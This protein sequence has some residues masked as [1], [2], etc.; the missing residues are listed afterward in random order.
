MRKALISMVIVALMLTFPIT[1]NDNLEE[2]VQVSDLSKPMNEYSSLASAGGSGSSIPATQYM[3]R[4]ITSEQISILNT[5]ADTSTHFGEIDLSS[6]LNPG[7]HV[8]EVTVD[9]NSM[10]AAPERKILADT[11][12]N[13]NFQIV[14]SLGVFYS[15]LV[16]GFYAQPH[17][18]Q[19]Q[20][21]SIYYY[22]DRYDPDVRGN[23]SFA[24]TSNYNTSSVMTTPLNLTESDATPIWTTIDGENVPLDANIVYWA[25]IN[26]STC[27][28]DLVF[29]YYPT[30]F[31]VGQDNL[32]TFE[33]KW[34][35]PPPENEWDERNVEALLNYTYTPWNRTAGAALEFSSPES[36]SL[37]ADS[38]VQTGL[39]WTFTDGVSNITSI[40]FNANQSIYLNYDITIW[41]QDSPT[42]TTNWNVDLSGNPVVWNAT[43][44]L[45]YPVFPETTTKYLDMTVQTD[46]DLL[47]LYNSTNPGANYTH[48]SRVGDVVTCSAMADETWTLSS[49]APNYVTAIALSNSIDSSPIVDYVNISV[50][51]DIDATVEDA[52]STPITGG[53]TNLTVI[54]S[55]TGIYKPARIAA[56]GGNAGFTWDIDSTTSG[57]GTHFVE[58]FWT[59]GLEAGYFATQVFVYYPT[60]LVSDDSKVTAYA[61]NAAAFSIGINFDRVYP[62]DGMDGSFA[63]VTYSFGAVVNASLFDQGGGRW[64]ETISTTG[65][66]NGTYTLYVY[67]EGYALENQSLTITVKLIYQTQAL[68]V[69]WSPTN[70]IPYLNTTKL[71]I[72]YRM[73][74]GTN[75]TGATVNVSI[76][77]TAYDMAWD[78]FTETYWIELTGEN[79]TGVPDTFNLNVSAWGAGYET[80]FDDTVTITI[81]SQTGEVFDADY[82]PSTL[83]ISYI[84]TLFIQVT[85]EYNS[86][87]INSSTTVTI[88]FNGSSPVALLYNAT[89]TK[90]EVTLQ[91]SDYFGT[92]AI[93]VTATASGYT[94]RFNTTTFIVH[95]DSPILSSDWVGDSATTIYDIGA[96]LTISL[97]D[98]IGIPITDAN[99]S[100]TAFGTLYPLSS[101]VGGL[102]TF[103]I[104]PG[105]IWGIESFTVY[106]NRT[107]FTSLQMNLNLTV[108]APTSLEFR[109]LVSSE[110]EEWNLTLEARYMDTFYS[111]PIENATVTVTLYGTDYMLQYSA[112]VYSIEIIL[113]SAPGEY[114]IYVTAS[115]EY[116]AY[117]ANQAA[118]TVHPKEYVYLEVTFDGDLIAGQFIEIRATLRSNTT[119][120]PPIAGETIRFEVSVYFDNGTII[121]Y[122]DGT[123]IDS[124]NT[125]GVATLGFE[126]PFGN[127]LR[128]T[129]HAI[130]D[131]SQF[132]WNAEFTEETGV[133]VSPLSLLLAFFMSDIGIL[134]IISIAFLGIVAAGY[135]RGVKPKKKAAKLTLENELQMFKDLETVQHFMAV[136][137]DRGTCVFYHP[138]T[139]E[140]IQ[141]DLISGF[142]AAITSVYGEIK[143]DGVRGTLEEIQYHGLRL[144]SYSGQYII[145]ILILEGEMTTLLRERLQFFV[146]LFE[147]QY[148]HDLDG[149]TGLVDCFD[150]EWVVSTLNSAF[151]YAWHLPHR[152]GP[153]Q[154]VTKLDAKILDYIGAVRDERS[155][156][157]FKNLISPLAEMLD[158]TEPEVLDR[159]LLLQDRGII[160]PIGIQTILQRQ[161]LALVNGS[162]D[163]VPEPPTTVDEPKDEELE[164][165]DLSE[166]VVTEPQEAV[167]EESESDPMEAFVQDVESLLVA[168]ADDEKE[169]DDELDE[170]VKDLRAKIDEDEDSED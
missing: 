130:Y 136:Y 58:V 149:W 161:G 52:D 81:G 75:I 65:M 42:V 100:F 105:A 13:T 164:F 106:V 84:E 102:Y 80:Q 73:M 123:M 82:I 32:G 134:M 72:T 29:S 71:S 151:N 144:N 26:G 97:T 103:D 48:A 28:P 132:R 25:L 124:T 92:W 54:Q 18:G 12:N 129:A 154:K 7:W 57:N 165:E 96:P 30:V 147:N 166:D 148:D 64:T 110:Y 66:T 143:G 56:L 50:D 141:P 119:D 55:G 139:D 43:T 31:W 128:L 21:Y 19:L 109:N 17:D 8:Y 35:D 137:L 142:I 90:W 86:L 153:T 160:A 118:F 127:I 83:N 135:N 70:N 159:L 157:Y 115:A 167:V 101:G 140:R 95:E 23:A 98:S 38:V 60:T 10:V 76:Q 111:M 16:Q 67:S 3:S 121:H 133:E 114:T 33:S 79:F 24:I 158:K 61:D 94:T 4:V 22:T 14:E 36:L 59:N 131:G 1:T 40:Q 169:G 152:F 15:Q 45:S 146:E 89:S 11:N 6:Y 88:T 37:Q 69:S 117:A 62:V 93:N 155:E 104:V 162:D 150:P 112:G 68:S 27:Y 53:L 125:E 170:F 74:D 145:G 156:F 20:N 77:G 51:M 9:V 138:F 44:T 39:S 126:V 2:F 34:Y 163:F 46:W 122:T 41:Y 49:S 120:N 87:P 78:P 47:G 107:G 168:K 116:A 99:V 108:E 113:S 91:G 63:N 85:Y 5:Y